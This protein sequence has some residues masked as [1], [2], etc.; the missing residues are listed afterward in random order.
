MPVNGKTE[1]VIIDE[2]HSGYVVSNSGDTM[3]FDVTYNQREGGKAEPFHTEKYRLTTTPEK[4]RQ[5]ME[6]DIR[7]LNIMIPDAPYLEA[8][9]REVMEAEPVTYVDYNTQRIT[10]FPAWDILPGR[11]DPGAGIM[12]CAPGSMPPET[13]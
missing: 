6:V 13:P 10:A 2:R 3:V 9:L 8:G 1:P 7:T 11:D 12:H 4:E 5:K